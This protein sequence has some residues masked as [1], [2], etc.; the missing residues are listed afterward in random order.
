MSKILTRLLGGPAT[1][2]K[3]EAQRTGAA[4]QGGSPY[5]MDDVMRVPGTKFRF[6]LDPLLGLHPRYR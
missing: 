4:L 3:G 5:I 2:G 1:G 6:G